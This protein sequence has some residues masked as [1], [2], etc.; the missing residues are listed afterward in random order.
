MGQ[1][2]QEDGKYESINQENIDRAVEISK[3]FLERWGN[4]KAFAAFEPINEPWWDS[5]LDVLKDFYRRIRLL[6]Q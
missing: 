4:H 1:W 5:D 3:S 2:N 6:V